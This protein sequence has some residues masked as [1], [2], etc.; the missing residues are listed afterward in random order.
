MQTVN[1]L[2]VICRSRPGRDIARLLFIAEWHTDL[3][4]TGTTELFKL[5]RAT[6]GRGD[7]SKEIEGN[8]GFSAAE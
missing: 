6:E 2:F 7:D 1:Q 3:R 4:L 5:R 8:Y